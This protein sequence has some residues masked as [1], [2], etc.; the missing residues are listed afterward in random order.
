MLVCLVR[1]G[2]ISCL[3]NIFPSGEV[4]AITLRVAGDK[5]GG[6]GQM[7]GEEGIR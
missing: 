4:C 1:S 3:G 6:G 2:N 5:K 7:S